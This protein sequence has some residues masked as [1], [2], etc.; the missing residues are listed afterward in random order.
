MKGANPSTKLLAGFCMS[1]KAVA[2]CMFSRGEWSLYYSNTVYTCG[3]VYVCVC[4]CVYVCV[5]VCGC[6]KG[7][8]VWYMWGMGEDAW[9]GNIN[10]CPG[11]GTWVARGAEVATR[12]W[13]LEKEL[14]RWLDRGLDRAWT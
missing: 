8:L 7:R 5:Y 12:K 1:E 9:M 2:R 4:M 13:V 3:W 11:E 14:L 10:G 6:V